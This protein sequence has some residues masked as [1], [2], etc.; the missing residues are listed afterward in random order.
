MERG[1]GQ[2]MWATIT[3]SYLGDIFLNKMFRMIFLITMIL[4][5]RVG[6]AKLAIGNNKAVSTGSRVVWAQ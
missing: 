6:F 5:Y 3:V 4:M 2:I 1:Q